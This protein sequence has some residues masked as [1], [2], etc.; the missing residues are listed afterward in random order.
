MSFHAQSDRITGTLIT[1]GT[2]PAKRHSSLHD[3]DAM[4][5][6]LSK[7][8]Q[9]SVFCN[10]STIAFGYFRQQEFDDQTNRQESLGPAS[11]ARD[12]SILSR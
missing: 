11:N 9:I 4:K 7:N 6:W 8:T 10:R 3:L 1:D 5:S 2:V 12:F